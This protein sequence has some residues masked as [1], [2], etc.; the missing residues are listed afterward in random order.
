VSLCETSLCYGGVW[1][2]VHWRRGGVYGG[3]DTRIAVVVSACWWGVELLW[4]YKIKCKGGA[5]CRPP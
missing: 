3:V 2:F 1:M 4:S 5:R